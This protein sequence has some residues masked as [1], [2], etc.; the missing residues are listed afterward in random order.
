M[1]FA[2]LTDSLKWIHLNGELWISNSFIFIFF[3]IIKNYYKSQK[4]IG[5]RMRLQRASEGLSK[6]PAHN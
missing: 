3:D 5:L 4:A 1:N 6:V 2:F